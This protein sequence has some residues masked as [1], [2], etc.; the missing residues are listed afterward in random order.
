MKSFY[1]IETGS[2]LIGQ[3]GSLS[4]NAEHPNLTENLP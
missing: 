2:N 3:N 1:K 4:E